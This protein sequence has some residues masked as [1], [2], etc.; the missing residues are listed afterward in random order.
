MHKS[1]DREK[2]CVHELIFTALDGGN[3]VKS[4]TALVQIVVQ[5][6]NDN[7]PNFDIKHKCMKALCLVR[8]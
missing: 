7:K 6:N 8:V 5:D 4:G 2:Q 3:P 1:L